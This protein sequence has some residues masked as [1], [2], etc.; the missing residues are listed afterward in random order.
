MIYR[1]GVPVDEDFLNDFKGPDEHVEQ[2]A[3]GRAAIAAHYAA[4]NHRYRTTVKRR[5]GNPG[6]NGQW[7]CSIRRGGANKYI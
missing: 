4:R 1:N 2:R 3:E 7:G 6:R 5:P